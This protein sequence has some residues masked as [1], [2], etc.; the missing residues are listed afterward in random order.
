MDMETILLK[1][2]TAEDIILFYEQFMDGAAK[3]P[4]IREILGDSWIINRPRK[5][6]VK[7]DRVDVLL[8]VFD[9]EELFSPFYAM[10]SELC[11][12]VLEILVWYGQQDLET[13]EKRVGKRIATKKQGKRVHWEPFDL[14]PG[15]ELL[16]LEYSPYSIYGR[17]SSRKKDVTAY[18]PNVLREALRQVMP[19][20][21]A[22]NLIPLKQRG[23]AEFTH[24][25]EPLVLSE[26]VRMVDF[27]KQGHLT[28]KKNGAPT[29]KGL[30]DLVQV[31]NLQEFYP[32][33]TG[34]ELERL[35]VE[36]LTSF[37]LGVGLDK[38]DSSAIPHKL[39]QSLFKNWIK[40]PDYLLVEQLLDHLRINNRS[41]YFSEYRNVKKELH[42]IFK[43]LPVDK[44]VSLKNIQE[45]CQVREVNLLERE[46]RALEYRMQQE[47]SYGIRDSW[48]YVEQSTLYPVV[49]L[50]MLQ[51]FFFLTAALGMVEIAYDKPANKLIQRPNRDYLSPFDGLRSVRLTGL[52]AYIIGKKKTYSPAV[53]VEEKVVFILDN[54]RLVLTM[55]GND[56][57]AA[58][59][60]EKMLKPVGTGRFIMTFESLFKG[61]RNKREV[62]A[63]IAQ[64][65][66]TVCKKPPRIWQE[67]FSQALARINPLTPEPKLKVLKVGENEEL[68]NLLASDPDISQLISKVEGLRIA[69]YSTDLTKLNSLLRRHG[70]LIAGT[71]LAG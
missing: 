13:L 48:E 55:E 65:K 63:K 49:Y 14:T 29:V 60:L 26:F 15:L 61:C 43:K 38:A 36:L 16:M 32:A 51:A 10:Q 2:Y 45:Y 12:A 39:L 42:K 46:M 17:K 57:I 70:Y 22:Y 59:T 7:R 1:L 23:I 34:T 58:L 3:N 54:E 25:S 27:I 69:V 19:K 53:Q 4:D 56:P 33:G 35:K 5:K 20:P 21:T 62:Q 11:K 30:R 28:L 24:T 8:E 41:Y 44:W 37:L 68:L 66:K 40:D 71:S 9:T 50:P 18:L 67:F 52:G 64:F 47:T 6:M 31:A